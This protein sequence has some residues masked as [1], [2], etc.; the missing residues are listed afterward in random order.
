MRSEVFRAAIQNRS[1]LPHK[2]VSTDGVLGSRQHA[3]FIF[4]VKKIFLAK[5]KIKFIFFLSLLQLISSLKPAGE[6]DPKACVNKL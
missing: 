4:R 3:Q 5:L 1:T 6:D 2:M